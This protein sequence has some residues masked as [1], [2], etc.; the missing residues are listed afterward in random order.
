M[1]GFYLAIGKQGSGKSAL[2]IKF[3]VD[4]YYETGRKVFAN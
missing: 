4:S 1:N 2:S 3:L